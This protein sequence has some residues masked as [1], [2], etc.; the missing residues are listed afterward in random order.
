MREIDI[1]AIKTQSKKERQIRDKEG[2]R[3]SRRGREREGERK[4]EGYRD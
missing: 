1:D 2:G 3:E 4:R